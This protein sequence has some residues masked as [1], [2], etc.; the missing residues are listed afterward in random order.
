VRKQTVGWRAY[1]MALKLIPRGAF[2]DEY[3]RAKA[4]DYARVAWAKGYAA[5]K[6]EA[7]QQFRRRDAKP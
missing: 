7:K 4:Q 2:G 5:A 3:E 1:K 6:R